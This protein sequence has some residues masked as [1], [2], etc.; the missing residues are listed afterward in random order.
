MPCLCTIMAR[1]ARMH[2]QEIGQTVRPVVIE[3]SR[4]HGPNR[5]R[6][7]GT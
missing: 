6:Q 4:V 2:T 3:A 7:D 1:W 5:P